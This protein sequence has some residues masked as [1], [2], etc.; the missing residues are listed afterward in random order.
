ME[1]PRDGQAFRPGRTAGTDREHSRSRTVLHVTA[2]YA[3]HEGMARTAGEL[4]SRIAGFDHHL[5]TNELRTPASPFSAV[6]EVGGSMPFFPLTRADAIQALVARARPDLVHVHGGVLS[7]LLAH[8]RAFPAPVVA[9]VYGWAGPPSR[10]ELRGSTLAELRGS[11]VSDARVL[12]AGLLPDPVLRRALGDRGRVRA[13]LTQDLEIARRLRR[14]SAVPVRLAEFGSAVDGRRAVLRLDAPVIAF[15]GR[16][17]TAR[18]VDVVIDAMP[19]VLDRVPAA[20]LRLFLLDAPQLP[21]VVRRVD[22][23]PARGAIEVVGR[24]APDLREE[25]LR[26]T[27]AAFPFKFDHVAPAPP[28]TVVEAMSVGLPVVVTPVRCLEQVVEARK[29]AYVVPV[30]DPGAV[31][32]A[33]VAALDPARWQRMSDD[34][35]ALVRERWNWTNAAQVTSRLYEDVLGGR[36]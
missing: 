25:L 8:G 9:S 28:L 24:P 5:C 27:V 16:A 2:A 21:D 15:A 19:A 20:R 1:P 13:V 12:L 33:V 35:L 18:G 22:A 26:C 7:I 11:P 10:A 30:R 34:A 29:G 32:R 14:L 23:S 31:A 17:E 36:D 3:S 6:T 4:A